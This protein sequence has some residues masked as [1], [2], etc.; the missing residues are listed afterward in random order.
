MNLYFEFRKNN[1]ETDEKVYCYFVAYDM[2]YGLLS[3]DLPGEV[4]ALALRIWQEDSV[5]VS[6]F[7]NKFESPAAEM[8][9]EEFLVIK[10]KS[11]PIMLIEN[12]V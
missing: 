7:K 5:K 2:T 9:M 6:Y 11:K 8:D 12:H 10:L 3:R 1:A 4:T